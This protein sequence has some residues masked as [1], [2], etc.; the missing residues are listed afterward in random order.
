MITNKV[1]KIHPCRK[2][3]CNLKTCVTGSLNRSWSSME[4]PSAQLIPGIRHYPKLRVAMSGASRST[5]RIFTARL[6][7][8]ITLFTFHGTCCSY[9]LKIGG[10]ERGQLLS[11]EELL[12]MATVIVH[13]GFS[14]EN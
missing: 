1:T 10:H 7:T 12:H 14:A 2:F 11:I 9:V 3:T 5:Y 13:A 8:Q 4:E 6:L